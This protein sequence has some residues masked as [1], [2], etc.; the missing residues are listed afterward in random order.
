MRGKGR[1]LEDR[2]AWEWDTLAVL[3]GCPDLLV[4]D[5]HQPWVPGQSAFPLWSLLRSSGLEKRVSEGFPHLCTQDSKHLENRLQSCVRWRSRGR[6]W[7]VPGFTPCHQ[8]P[9]TPKRSDSHRAGHS[10]GLLALPLH[11]CWQ[12]RRT[13]RAHNQTFRQRGATR[14]VN[15]KAGQLSGRGAG[16]Y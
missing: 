15:Y 13:A 9:G 5:H 6:M 7:A 10:P 14:D 16:H 8:H 3:T 4:R 2:P 11:F 1:N 12:L